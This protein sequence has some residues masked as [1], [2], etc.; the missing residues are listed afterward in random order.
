M[1]SNL[2]YPYDHKAYVYSVDD[3]EYVDVSER[4]TTLRVVVEEELFTNI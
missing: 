1:Y 4:N 3:V 2:K